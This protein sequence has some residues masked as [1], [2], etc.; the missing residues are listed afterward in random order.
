MPRYLSWIFISCLIG[1]GLTLLVI[2]FGPQEGLETLG[3]GLL[4]YF[5]LLYHIPAGLIYI[6][7]GMGAGRR[8][9]GYWL[10]ILYFLVIWGIG[11]W[12]FIIINDLD[13]A[14]LD[15]LEAQRDPDSY[16]LRELGETLY[17]QTA[18]GQPIPAADLEQ[19]RNL[20]E[21][22]ERV[23]QRDSRHRAPLWYAAAL[24]EVQSVRALLAKGA[25]TDDK[26]LYW[27]TPLAA[28]V[29]QGQ[30]EAVQVLLAHGANPDEGENQ[31]YP[32]V[33]LATKHGNLEMVEALVSGDAD[34][35]L[36]D[37]APFSI[38]LYDR[39]A[40]IAAVLLEAGAAPV[41]HFYRR[42]PLE[43][44]LE[45]DDAD[46]VALLLE[47][48]DGFEQRSENR[49]PMLFIAMSACDTEAFS[50][51]LQMGASPDVMD[52]DGRRLLERLLQLNTRQCD[53]DTIRVNLISELL[54]AG[55][56]INYSNAT[57]A[58]P[59]VIALRNNQLEIARRLIAEG[60][61]LKGR[62]G[63]R[64]FLIMATIA[65]ADDLVALA[66]DQGFDPSA[67][68]DDLNANTALSVAARE[69]HTEIVRLMLQ[70]EV[71]FPTT[72]AEL[73]ILFG[74][75]AEHGEVLEQLLT[76]YMELPEDARNDK[77]VVSGIRNSKVP[78]AQNI[79]AGF[80]ALLD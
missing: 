78:E 63:K 34:V 38:A 53:F 13:D 43:V 57:G 52:R 74:S 51:Y 4:A 60:A 10:T 59:V 32:S 22:A 12:Q 15:A 14:A 80:P 70:H 42:H 36:G 77:A 73:S 8:T 50:Q 37:P 49:D 62:I 72:W 76:G 1:S 30:V 20:T 79:L 21:L 26:S 17:R 55:V 27:T 66:L 29:D 9:A 41:V 75:A 68:A 46:M 6:L 48:T 31:H 54:E 2:L 33:S 23:N 3:T 7:G 5:V 16:D 25:L 39:R 71:S 58:T 56:D 28:A 45:N 67:E 18:F 47:H 11:A 61:E 44:A 64:N 40:D 69:G 19:F 24:G 35:N 65:G